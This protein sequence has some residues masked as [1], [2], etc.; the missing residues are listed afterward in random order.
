MPSQPHSP[1]RE[2]V[3]NPLERFDLTSLWNDED[4]P[5]HSQLAEL[6]ATVQEELENLEKVDAVEEVPTQ[7]D[8]ELTEKDAKRLREQRLDRWLQQHAF[9]YSSVI[10][11]AS[12]TPSCHHLAPLPPPPAAATPPPQPLRA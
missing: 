8:K 12:R 6:I 9:S 4:A 5:G 2:P 3:V 10:D 11:S 1:G 7:A